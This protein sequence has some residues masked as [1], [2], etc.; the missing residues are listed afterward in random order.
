[1]VAKITRVLAFSCSQ[2]FARARMLG[3]SRNSL[4]AHCSQEKF[5]NCSQML[6]KAIRISILIDG[7]QTLVKVSKLT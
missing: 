6:A 3:L 5:D 7:K 2:N 4:N 1:M